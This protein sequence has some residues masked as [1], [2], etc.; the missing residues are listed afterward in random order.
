MNR[1]PEALGKQRDYYSKAGIFASVKDQLDGNGGGGDK[2]VA[3]DTTIAPEWVAD[4]IYKWGEL[5]TYEGELYR[6]SPMYMDNPNTEAFDPTQWYK[7]SMYSVLKNRAIEGLIDPTS[8]AP[9]YYYDEE[10]PYSVGDIVCYNPDDSSS[11]ATVKS[12]W[13]LFRASDADVSTDTSF[14]PEHWTEISIMEY[15]DD[16]YQ[17]PVPVIPKDIEPVYP[18]LEGSDVPLSDLL[19]KLQTDSTIKGFYIPRMYHRLGTGKSIYLCTP[20][21]QIPGMMN[22]GCLK[23]KRIG[24]LE[25]G[26][27]DYDG[28]SIGLEIKNGSSLDSH[29]PVISMEDVLIS[30]GAGSS[31]T[32]RSIYINGI[33]KTH[34]SI[35]NNAE[36][37]VA[38]HLKYH[39][40]DPT[41]GSDISGSVPFSTSLYGALMDISDL[42][43]II[44]YT[45]FQNGGG[46]PIKIGEYDISDGTFTG[47]IVYGGDTTYSNPLALECLK[48][49]R[50]RL[51]MILQD[52]Y[53][54]MKTQYDVV[55]DWTQGTFNFPNA[56]YI[57]P[58]ALSCSRKTVDGVNY[59]DDPVAYL[60][61]K[62]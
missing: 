22:L 27:D 41:D 20:P 56:D 23:L 62:N 45:V 8:L 43:Q 26:E 2:S 13:K 59:A 25:S 4:K 46:I 36:V 15:L 9:K 54:S 57:L 18:V 47:P 1:E 49:V 14:D 40:E 61:K 42:F 50:E 21:Y 24:D 11:D 44:S 12:P 17:P 58:N 19:S 32:K 48:I 7:T 39:V 38:V 6:P 31:A 37:P 29:G 16:Y 53:Y 33:P 10:E 3:K 60:I 5:C 30:V 35:F 28:M 52:L 55:W 34:V 51:P